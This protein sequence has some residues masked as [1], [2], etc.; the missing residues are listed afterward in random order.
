[1][2]S[3]GR[4]TEENIIVADTTQKIFL[5]KN[6]GLL[7]AAGDADLREVVELL[8]KVKKKEG[9]WVLPSIKT[10]IGLQCDF[11]AILVLP[12][13]SVWLLECGLK[14][15]DKTQWYC[16]VVQVSVPFIAAGSGSKWAMGAMDR[17]ATALQAVKTA[18][19]YDNMCGGKPQIFKL[20]KDQVN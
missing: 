1:M 18:I 20:E 4:M 19:R 15:D 10:L 7:G 6:G 9:H 13:E 16:N 17:G 3:D 8:G 12:D 14:P 2:V 5:L 11:E